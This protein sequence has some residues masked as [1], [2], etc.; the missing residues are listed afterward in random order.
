MLLKKLSSNVSQI[1]SSPT[2]DHVYHR[3][4]FQLIWVNTTGYTCVR[5]THTQYYS[6]LVSHLSITCTTCLIHTRSRYF[7]TQLPTN[8]FWTKKIL[9]TIFF[10]RQNNVS[11]KSMVYHAPPGEGWGLHLYMCPTIG[12]FTSACSPPSVT[13]PLHVPHHWALHLFFVKWS[14]VPGGGMVNH[15]F[16]WHITNHYLPVPGW[17]STFFAFSKAICAHTGE[18]SAGNPYIGKKYINNTPHSTGTDLIILT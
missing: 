1:H 3:R 11:F 15:R 6:F 9:S 17:I 2:V 12:N 4:K 7:A 14:D 18:T 13:S 16:E 8:L 5:N 10:L